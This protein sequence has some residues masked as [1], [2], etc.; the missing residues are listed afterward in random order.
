VV[1]HLKSVSRNGTPPT[2]SIPV[3][4]N[5][6]RGAFVSQIGTTLGKIK[7]KSSTPP[8]ASKPVAP[9][10]PP[11]PLAKSIER[12]AVD[13]VELEL[14]S[15]ATA[16]ETGSSHDDS[17][18]AGVSHVAKSP[19]RRTAAPSEASE[20]LVTEP[21]VEQ[22]STDISSYPGLADTPDHEDDVDSELHIAILKST[23]R[24]SH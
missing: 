23:P 11:P 19:A 13:P 20:S 4:R 6:D 14:L 8:T 10:P 7:G 2:L 18:D 17:D 24:R 21:A 1:D 12:D 5:G 16:L 22:V 15:Q 3:L 9:P